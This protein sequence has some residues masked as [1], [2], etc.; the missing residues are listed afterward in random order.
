MD[1]SPISA[2]S[3]RIAAKILSS[4]PSQ[5]LPS[6]IDHLIHAITAASDL[7]SSGDSQASADSS[8]NL[9]V[10]VHKF[11]TQISTLL[12]SRILEGRWTATVLIKTTVE[13]GGWEV[14]KS[15]MPWVRGLLAILTVCLRT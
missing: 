4:T 8:G 9:S 1:S 6:K 12:H 15:C 5:R 11:K 3:L 2:S 14:L 10:T 7:L 13:A